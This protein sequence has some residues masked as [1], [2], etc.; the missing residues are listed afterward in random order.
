MWLTLSKPYR[1]SEDTIKG[2]Q[3]SASYT[4]F[5]FG[6]GGGDKANQ[7]SI[8]SSQATNQ[9]CIWQGSQDAALQLPCAPLSSQSLN[10]VTLKTPALTLVCAP[11]WQLTPWSPHSHTHAATAVS[12]PSSCGNRAPCYLARTWQLAS[13]ET[14]AVVATGQGRFLF[15][16]K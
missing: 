10:T 7:V 8:S 13:A 12:G 15:E 2:T 5:V 4:C 3:H 1:A 16:N 9:L 6:V 14:I 11:P